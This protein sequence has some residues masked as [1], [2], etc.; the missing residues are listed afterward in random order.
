[1]LRSL[2]NTLPGKPGERSGP[3]Q[4]SDLHH[5]GTTDLDSQC[6]SGDWAQCGPLGPTQLPPVTCI[7]SELSLASW[8]PL[9]EASSF[10]AALQITLEWLTPFSQCQLYMYQ[11]LSPCTWLLTPPYQLCKEPRTCSRAELPC[12]WRSAPTGLYGRDQ[13]CSL[14]PAVNPVTA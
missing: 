12:G 14:P 9:E 1:M 13:Q 5:P 8:W 7:P 10:P 2:C 3:G 6:Q 4:A 11:D